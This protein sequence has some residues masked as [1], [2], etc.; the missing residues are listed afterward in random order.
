M[1][2]EG[3][4][5]PWSAVVLYPDDDVAVALLDIAQGVEALVRAGSSSLAIPVRDDIP[6]GH[7]LAIRAMG[8]GAHVRKYG[9]VIGRLTAATPA[10]GHVHSHN[11]A[12]LRATRK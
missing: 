8:E 2:S 12:S 9:S 10:G 6:A 4:Q 11:L 1:S 7:K 5:R 3:V